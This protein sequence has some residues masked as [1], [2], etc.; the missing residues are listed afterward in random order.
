LNP[1]DRRHLF[2]CVGAALFTARV[3]FASAADSS[4]SDVWALNFWAL[5]FWAL[6]FWA[7]EFEGPEI[8]QMGPAATPRS[9]AAARRVMST[10][11]RTMEART[12]L[13]PAATLALLHMGCA[14]M[15]LM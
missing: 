1:G 6:N 12:A 15:S 8:E 13:P 7:F 11:P 9:S 5:N 4:S 10:P 3:I 2:K 14:A